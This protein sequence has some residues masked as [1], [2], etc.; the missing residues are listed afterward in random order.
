M[1]ISFLHSGTDAMASYRYRAVLPAHA[2]GASINDP[3]APVL[4]FSKGCAEDVD[5]LRTAKRE[6]RITI[7]DVCDVHWNSQRTPWWPTLIQEADQVVANT[8]FTARLLYEDFGVVA[9]V[10]DDP[11]EYPERV[12]HC[13]GARLLWFGHPTNGASAM[14]LLSLAD[15]YPVTI[16]TDMKK[17]DGDARA[18]C[19]QWSHELLATELAQADIV[20]MPETAPHKSANRTVEAIRSGCTVIAEP[21][22]SLLEFPRLWRGNLRK[23][24]TWAHLHPNDA[25]QRTAQQQKYIQE[26]FSLERV[27]NAWKSLVE[28]CRST[29]A[30]GEKSGLAGSML[31]ASG[32]SR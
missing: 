16:V 24:I 10:I 5:R 18:R 14:R 11:A 26:R 28:G 32:V 9:A 7:V 3:T 25:N 27:G 1:T 23:G 2:L 6:G 29:S 30:Q 4:V 19:L 21:H 20:L 31:T 13:A 12:P 17:W 8:A 15:E 22:P